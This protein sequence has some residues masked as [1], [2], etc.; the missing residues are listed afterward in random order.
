M[1][2]KKL[3]LLIKSGKRTYKRSL[4][5]DHGDGISARKSK[6]SQEHEEL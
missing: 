4:E 6:N 5:R 3:L 1:K 2:E